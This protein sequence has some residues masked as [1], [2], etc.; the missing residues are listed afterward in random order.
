MI[1]VIIMKMPPRS[2]ETSL[3]NEL[4]ALPG[5][6][7]MCQYSVK[8]NNT[9]FVQSKAADREGK[10]LMDYRIHFGAGKLTLTK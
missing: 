4:L 2:A 1:T 9:C 10:N 5:H 3:H 6:D 7:C 8:T